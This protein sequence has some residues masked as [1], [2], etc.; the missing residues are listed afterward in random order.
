[1]DED[2]RIRFMVAPLLFLASLVWGFARDP[3]VHL[4][5]FLPVGG[6]DL[7]DASSLIA[8]VTAGGLA[9]FVLGFVIGTTT[10]VVLRSVAFVS[11][12]WHVGSGCHEIVLSS[13]AQLGVW[14]AIKMP[15][16]PIPEQEL[17][18]GVTFDH[19][20]LFKDHNGVHRWLVRRWNAFSVAITSVMALLLS[21]AFGHAVVGIDWRGDWSTVA[22]AVCGVLLVSAFLAWR[23]TM[24]ML[25]FQAQR[26]DP[27]EI[28]VSSESPQNAPKAPSG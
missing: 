22:L 24:R 15:G 16:K 28:P 8:V 4:A 18:A 6:L 2:R 3:H 19:D 1:M 26:L 17:F 10:Y 7:K 11:K 5:R 14:R 9:V 23:D 12:W 25:T 13:D 27:G 20:V 21:L